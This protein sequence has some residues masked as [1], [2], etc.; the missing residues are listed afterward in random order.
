MK[1]K[2]KILSN[3]LDQV[4]KT[5]EWYENELKNSS[6]HNQ[7]IEALDKIQ[8]N[9]ETLDFPGL[10]RDKVY[11]NVVNYF[12]IDQ[13]KSRKFVDDKAHVK[14]I[15]QK[16]RNGEFTIREE[17]EIAKTTSDCQIFTLCV[18]PYTSKDIL[19]MTFDEVITYEGNILWHLLRA[20]ALHPNTDPKKIETNINQILFMGF[21]TSWVSSEN[22]NIFFS[23][24]DL[25]WETIRKI[26]QYSWI[27]PPR[28]IITWSQL[29]VLI[30]NK[31]IPEDLKK[32][33]LSDKKIANWLK[34]EHIIPEK[35]YLNWDKERFE[36]IDKHFS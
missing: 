10:D 24:P 7:I 23:K 11:R 17:L 36:F 13:Y 12:W 29:C 8:Y 5:W 14:S 35:A 27:F 15:E 25:T 1:N 6:V 19:D 30:H 26:I 3:D 34:N 9:I 33:L 4:P 22:S 32:E 21:N 18:S 28:D 16:I 2:P 31:N 20:I